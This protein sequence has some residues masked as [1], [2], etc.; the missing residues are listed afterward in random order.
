MNVDKI[1]EYLGK[2]NEPKYRL[3]QIIDFV[4]KGK[5]KSFSEIHILPLS[6]RRDLD[7]NFSVFSFKEDKIYKSKDLKS[8]KFAFIL[9]DNFKIET[10]LF[11]NTKGEWIC[12]LS[13][14]VGCPVMCVFCASGRKGLKRNLNYEEIADQSIFSRYFLVSNNLGDIKKVVYMGMGEPLY[15][16]DNLSKSIMILNKFLGIGKRNISVST[17]GYVPRIRDFARDFPQI[18]FSLSLHSASNDIRKKLVP[19]ASNYPLSQISKAIS[20]YIVMTNRKV[21]IEYVLLDGINNRIKDAYMIR[22]FLRST[23]KL[24]Y[25]VVNLIPYNPTN[26][27]FSAP[28]EE[29]CVKFKDLLL[30]LGIETTIRKSYGNDV[31][32]ACG[33]LAFE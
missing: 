31:F 13:T 10:S 4:F 2:N 29:D 19:L 11:Q 1:A 5:A 30:S 33:Q 12:C 24:S 8:F 25:F 32:G 18:N 14:Q 27:R 28:K 22:D 20:D 17:F 9:K 21:M 16:Y 23:A 26:S 7:S 15:N 3:S 6:L